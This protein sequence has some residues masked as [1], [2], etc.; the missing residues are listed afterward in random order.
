VGVGH[1]LSWN[2]TG[3][4]NEE[5][6]RVP[7][8]AVGVDDRGARVGSNTG[9]SNP[10]VRVH[11][12]PIV[13]LDKR[14]EGS[15]VIGGNLNETSRQIGLHVCDSVFDTL[16]KNCL[17]NGVLEPW[18]DEWETLEV[19]VDTDTSTRSDTLREVEGDSEDGS[20]IV[21]QGGAGPSSWTSGSLHVA[22]LA[23][24]ATKSLPEIEA[25]R[26]SSKD[27][28]SASHVLRS[29]SSTRASPDGLPVVIII[30]TWVSEH[31][32]EQRIRHIF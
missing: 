5:V 22:S 1:G 27:T 19:A 10:V 14:V 16:S 25:G 32:L 6:V 11:A 29:I 30:D 7:D 18:L 20:I 26:G 28:A 2:N 17:V 4:D 13:V 31:Q 15:S 3:V 24:R 21:W 8:L 12:S 9:R 23:I